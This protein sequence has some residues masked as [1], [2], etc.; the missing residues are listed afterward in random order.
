MAF[1]SVIGWIATATAVFVAP[2]AAQQLFDESKYPAFEGQ[3][4]RLGAI[5]RYD[6]TKPPGRGQEAP[7]TPE[8][9][10]IFEA[11]LADVVKG[12]FGDDPVYS[13]IL[14]GMPR[15]MNLI[16]PM[17]IVIKRNTTYF[18]ME[19]LGMLRRIY[20][21]G[22]NFPDDEGQSWMGY[23]VGKWI[24]EDG[25]GRY[26]VLEI[27]TRNLKNPRTYDASGVPVHKDA[28]TVVKERLYLD[29]TNPDILYD[30][31]TTIDHALTRP[32]TV[33]KTMHRERKPLWIEAVCA[34]DNLQ[35]NIGNEHYMLNSA[36]ELMPAKKDQ[37]PPDLKH[38]NQPK[39]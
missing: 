25:D 13:C 38:F 5:E 15:A 11:N 6:Q 33:T 26:D 30:Q 1:R 39:K 29:K 12:G 37:P 28:Q 22:R 36:R 4:I 23:S 2:V 20:T 16:L 17:E 7:L 14:E 10:A 3:W 24:D 34:E 19:Y 21:D 9:Q 35:V 27:E 32:W 18:L 31:I 8:Y